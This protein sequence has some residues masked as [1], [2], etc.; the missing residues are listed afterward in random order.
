MRKYAFIRRRGDQRGRD[1]A[2]RGANAAGRGQPWAVAR[3]NAPRRRRRH[4]HAPASV[5]LVEAHSGSVRQTL[6]EIN[7][8]VRD[9]RHYDAARL[10]S[11][12]EQPH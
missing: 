2:F 10:R 3:D 6:K 1:V 8:I 5:R 12:A 7:W 4:L 9:F 11:A